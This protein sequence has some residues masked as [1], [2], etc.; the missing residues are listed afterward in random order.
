MINHARNLLL[1]V[2]STN[3]FA[4]YPA[5]E[6]VPET[7]APVV[8]PSYLR[9]VRTEL[10][11]SRPDRMLLNYRG[12]QLLQLLHSTELREFV[13]DL[14]PRITYN[15]TQA[16]LFQHPYGIGFRQFA[17]APQHLHLFGELGQDPAVDGISRRRWMIEVEN[18]EVLVRAIRPPAD[19]VAV[20]IE[21]SSNLSGPIYL[22]GT[23]L[24]FYFR[25]AESESAVSEYNF[26]SETA[27]MGLGSYSA[28]NVTGMAWESFSLAQWAAFTGMDWHLFGG[29]GGVGDSAEYV[30]WMVQLDSRPKR[31]L[32]VVASALESLGDETTYELFGVSAGLAN[33]EPFKTFRALWHDH[34]Q[35]PYKLGGLLLAYIYQTERTRLSS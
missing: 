4:T 14:D 1:N 15:P 26:L 35:L 28:A 32:G 20:E 11:G 19:I 22:P 17:G 21:T 33:K 18:G 24:G 6:Y 30:E 27:L 23:E 29:V 34:T 2:K 10:F 12:Q 9:R 25:D 7:F 3:D 16:A 31:D 5:E 8:L 13:L